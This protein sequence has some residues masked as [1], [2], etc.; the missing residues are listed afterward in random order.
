[1]KA[2]IKLYKNTI[3]FIKFDQLL[4]EIENKMTSQTQNTVTEV[5]LVQV[6]HSWH[7]SNQHCIYISTKENNSTSILEW[8]YS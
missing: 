7:R 8:Y 4:T 1:M 5:Y 2:F 6:L 3:N